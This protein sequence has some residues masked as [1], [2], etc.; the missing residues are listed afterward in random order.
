V[1]GDSHATVDGADVQAERHFSAFGWDDSDKP[2]LASGHLGKN[3]ERLPRLLAAFPN[4]V[5]VHKARPG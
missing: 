3:R 4:F 2:K 5:A 1:R